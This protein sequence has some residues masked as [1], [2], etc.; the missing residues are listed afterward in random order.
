MKNSPYYIYMLRCEDDSVYTGIATDLIKRMTEHFEKTE[1]CAKYTLRH[2][3]KSL[4]C[5]WKTKNRSLA[6]KLEF[7]I[8]K[9]NK[10]EKEELI[11][12][13]DSFEKLLG[14]FLDKKEYKRLTK[15]EIKMIQGDVPKWS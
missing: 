3:A 6:S 11:A 15:K 2:S 8:K 10:K 7:R 9:L 14:E 5:V 1:S 4:E 12:K 13:N